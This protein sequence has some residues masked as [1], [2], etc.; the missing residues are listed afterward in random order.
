MNQ[1]AI[2]QSG[3]FPPMADPEAQQMRDAVLSELAAKSEHYLAEYSNRFGNV[4]NADDAATLFDEYNRDRARYRVAV[5]PAA[6]WIRDELFR[7]SLEI[8]SEGPVSV[9]FTSGANAVGKSSAIEYSQA[10]QWAHTVFDS[11]FSN[12]AHARSLIEAA[13][14]A[15]RGISILHVDRPLEETL[16]AM[17][18][19]SRLEGRV[20]R[21]QQIIHSH[22]GAAETVRALWTEFR[23]DTRFDFRF[24]ANSTQGTREASIELTEPRDYTEIRKH[25]HELLDFEYRAGRS[26]RAV[27]DG[28]RG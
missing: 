24:F 14:A 7:R 5:H 1:L 23:E 10:R 2:P 21:I 22:Q 26:T 13:L 11:T 6:T 9:V 12:G 15:G 8:V 27:Y 19:R 3:G 17:L 16:L 4:L 25:L 18:D 28:V 20:V